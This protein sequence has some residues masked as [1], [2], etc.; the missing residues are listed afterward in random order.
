MN[1]IDVIV[2]LLDIPILIFKFVMRKLK[3]RRL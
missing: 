1:C 2:T 3:R